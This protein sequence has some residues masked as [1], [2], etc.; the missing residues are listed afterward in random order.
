VTRVHARLPGEIRCGATQPLL[1]H[2]AQAP[3]NAIKRALFL[4]HCASWQVQQL[5]VKAKHNAIE[6]DDGLLKLHPPKPA[7]PVGKLG[8]DE[9][10]PGRAVPPQDWPS[11]FD[12]VTIAVVKG[13][14]RKRRSVPVRTQA[15]V[16]CRERY[17]VEALVMQ[18]RQMRSRNAGVISRRRFGA[19]VRATR[20]RT[21]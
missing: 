11:V 19:N 10:R 17:D 2:G 7:P 6:P 15:V 14:G 4:V 20:G 12:I 18:F 9:Q 8:R 16:D 13:Q 5:A 1:G 3:V 21:W